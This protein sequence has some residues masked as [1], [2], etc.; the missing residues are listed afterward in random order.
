MPTALSAPV[1][2]RGQG[3]NG[4]LPE[5]P[6]WEWLERAAP[7]SLGGAAR[8]AHAHGARMAPM[9]PM[10]AGQARVG[11]GPGTRQAVEPLGAL[12]PFSRELEPLEPFSRERPL[13]PFSREME[14]VEPF[15]REVEPLDVVGMVHDALAARDLDE[16]RY[17]EPRTTSH[18][19]RTTG[20]ST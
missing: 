2:R 14:P 6:P 19:P 13:E 20:L 15:S 10:A 12:E 8:P 4:R 5:A 17:P 3:R 7:R 11:S 9:P 16:V 1:C 18:E